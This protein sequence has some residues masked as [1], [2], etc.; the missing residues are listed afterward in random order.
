MQVL[1]LGRHG[2]LAQDD[3]AN[4]NLDQ[5]GI[6]KM[7]VL[8]LAA[9]AQDDNPNLDDSSGGRQTLRAAGRGSGRRAGRR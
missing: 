4:L 5:E 3:K 2:D 7:Q 1:R 6:V 9:L 8:R